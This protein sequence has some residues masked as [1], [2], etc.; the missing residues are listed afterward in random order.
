MLAEI[1]SCCLQSSVTTSYFM[2]YH[3]ILHT[4]KD[5]Y[6]ALEEARII[7]D[8]ITQAINQENGS[9]YEVFPYR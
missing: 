1:Y 3:T 5:Y 8:N 9:A 2:T 6:K 4:S 7:S